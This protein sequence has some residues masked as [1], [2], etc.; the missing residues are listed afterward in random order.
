MESWMMWFIL[1]GVILVLEFL[2][3][4]F[5]LIMIALG[6]AAGGIASLAGLGPN[7]QA[8]IAAAVWIVATLLLRRTKWGKTR[9][10]DS[11]KDPNINMD[12]GQQVQVDVWTDQRSARVMYRGA[13]WD[14]ELLSGDAVAGTFVIRE[15]RASRLF[16]EKL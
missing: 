10:A 2:S 11:D 12:I 16:V 1:A 8:L 14:V 15:I 13:M 7:L 9:H 3:G 4:T 6:L 5:Y